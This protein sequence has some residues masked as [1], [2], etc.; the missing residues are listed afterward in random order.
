[1]NYAVELLGCTALSAVEQRG[2]VRRFRVGL[3]RYLGG[4][5]NVPTFLAAFEVAASDRVD[6]QTNA[7]KEAALVYSAAHHMATKF[8]F[9]DRQAPEGATFE[10]WPAH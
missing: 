10:V 4:A 8:A 3:A 7:F 5:K 1:V 2:V 6:R 9:A